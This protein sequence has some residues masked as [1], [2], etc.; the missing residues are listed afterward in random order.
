MVALVALSCNPKVGGAT[1]TPPLGLP[2]RA[3]TRGRDRVA[4][5]AEERELLLVGTVEMK[6]EDETKR[7][8]WGTKGGKDGF[9]LLGILGEKE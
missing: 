4:G 1:A 6:V 2:V 3:A 7:F 8:E 5:G 9:C